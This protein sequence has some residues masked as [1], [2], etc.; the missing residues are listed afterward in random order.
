VTASAQ[1]PLCVIV[2]TVSGKAVLVSVTVKAA[3]RCAPVFGATENPTVPL[4]A[5]DAPCVTVRKAWLLTAP[6]VQ[7][8]DVLMDIVA[9]PPAAGKDVVVLPVIT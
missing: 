2:T 4:P 9:E 1:G 5:P 6:H 3:V 7:V 8:L